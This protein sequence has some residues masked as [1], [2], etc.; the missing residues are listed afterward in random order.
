MPA[1]SPKYPTRLP[2][3]GFQGDHESRSLRRATS[4]WTWKPQTCVPSADALPK[5]SWERGIRYSATQPREST[6][7][8]TSQTASQL[9]SSREPSYSSTSFFTPRG[10]TVKR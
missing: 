4:R 3:P 1:T 2:S 9:T 6:E 10:L 8:A 5:R 7:V